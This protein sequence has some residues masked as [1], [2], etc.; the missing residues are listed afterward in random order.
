MFKSASILLPLVSMFISGN[1]MSQETILATAPRC[2]KLFVSGKDGYHTY[3]IPG[4]AVTTEGTILAVCEGRKNS[5]VDSGDIDLL[6]KRSED[7]GKTWSKQQVIWDDGDN[8]C[9][10]PCMVIDYKTGTIWLLSTWNNGKDHE[11]QIIDQ[12]ST[13]TRRIFVF[14]STDDGITWS[15]PVEIT[16]DVKRPDWT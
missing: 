9:G 1:V 12:A 4:I 7:N 2:Q 10:N 11:Y 5:S 3:R 6:I 14:Y 16:E 8:T 13:D 15:K